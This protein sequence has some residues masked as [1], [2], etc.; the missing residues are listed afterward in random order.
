VAAMKIGEIPG[1][2]ENLKKSHIFDD[3]KVHFPASKFISECRG[4]PP[5]IILMS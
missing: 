5:K 2:I 4:T 1:E 3:E